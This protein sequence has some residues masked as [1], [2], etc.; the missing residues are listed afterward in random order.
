M[1]WIAANLLSF[2]PYPARLRP[3]VRDTRPSKDLHPI[4]HG[5][6]EE[7]RRTC[8]DAKERVANKAMPVIKYQEF[9]P[10][11]VLQNYVKRY[12][13]L[14]KEYAAE[15]SVEEVIPDACVELILNFGVAYAQPVHL[16]NSNPRRP[17][18][19][20]PLKLWIVNLVNV[21]G[22]KA[23]QLV[24]VERDPAPDVSFSLCSLLL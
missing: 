13:I 22:L 24:R 16:R 19:G 23:R 11:P 8:S 9:I 1:Q 5:A 7:S 15:D 20:T 2:S 14:E 3:N 21:D 4:Y 18:E 17:T 12:W 6:D 10:H